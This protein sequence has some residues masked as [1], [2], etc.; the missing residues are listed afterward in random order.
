M[1]LKDQIAAAKSGAAPAAAPAPLA[2]PAPAKKKGGPSF[3]EKLTNNSFADKLGAA[4]DVIAAPVGLAAKALPGGQP[5]SIAEQ[6]RSVQAGFLPGLF[7]IVKDEVGASI[8]HPFSAPKLIYRTAT[9][10]NREGSLAKDFYKTFHEGSPF[11]AGMGDSLARTGLRGWELGNSQAVGQFTP[12]SYKLN[13]FKNDKNLSETQYGQAVKNGTIVPT[14]IEDAGNIAIVAG[15]AA[16]LAG[17][18][19]ARAAS[20]EAALRAAGAS[21]AEIASAAAKAARRAAVADVANTFVD[22]ANWVADAPVRPL[23]VLGKAGREIGSAASPKVSSLLE[24]SE[25]GQRLLTKAAEFKDASAQRK[26]FREKMQNQKVGKAQDAVEP[27]LAAK[28]MKPE[29]VKLAEEQGYKGREAKA[30]A[31]DLESAAILHGSG[32][33]LIPGLLGEAP[34]TLRPGLQQG[35]FGVRNAPS[36]RALSMVGTDLGAKAADL[37]KPAKELLAKDEALRVEGAGMKRGLSEEQLGH[38]PMPSAIERVLSPYEKRAAKL[39]EEAALRSRQAMDAKAKIADAPAPPRPQRTAIL[40]ENIGATKTNRKASLAN[41]RDDVA[42]RENKQI[43]AWE[44]R[45][46]G[47]LSST[48]DRDALAAAKA[49]ELKG[50]ASTRARMAE[51]RANRVAR[52]LRTAEEK[53]ATLKRSLEEGPTSVAPGPYKKVLLKMETLKAGL[54]A[55]GETELAAKVPVT[56]KALQERGIFPE[57]LPGGVEEMAS[58][59]GNAGANPNMQT[60]RAA[61]EK[62]T[63]AGDMPKSVDRMMQ[64]LFEDRATR[65]GNVHLEEM[66]REVVKTPKQLI[67]E[68]IAKIDA[69][70]VITDADQ[71]RRLELEDMQNRGY[72]MYMYAKDKGLASIEGVAPNMIKPDSEFVPKA[73]LRDYREAIKSG[74]WEKSKLG[75]A[76]DTTTRGW[77]HANLALSPNWNVG[78]T[79]SNLGIMPVVRGGMNPLEIPQ[80]VRKV[81]ELRAREV[82]TGQPIFDPRVHSAGGV[83]EAR[84]EFDTAGNPEGKLGKVIDKGYKANESIDNLGKDMYWL[85]LQEKHGFSPAEATKQTLRVMG[86][87]SNLTPLESK[88]KRVMPFYSWQRHAATMGLDLVTKHPWRTAVAAHISQ[89]PRGDPSDPRNQVDPNNPLDTGVRLGKNWMIPIGGMDPFRSTVT[90]PALSP[91]DAVKSVNPIIKAGAYGL[92]DVNLGRLR[93]NTRP[94]GTGPMTASGGRKLGPASL[95]EDLY[96]LSQ[97][98][99]ISR[100]LFAAGSDNVARYDQGS[101]MTS[102]KKVIKQDGPKIQSVLKPFGLPIPTFVDADKQAKNKKAQEEKKRK[103]KKAAQ[104]AKKD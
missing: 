102:K 53:A 21:E 78:N 71:R 28:R 41:F 3:F 83:A 96:F 76:Y 16:K 79:V 46:R 60:R 8:K 91:V 39:R 62:M 68:E 94:A 32:H 52:T 80:F 55:A 25:A 10:N 92:L 57:Y 86:D 104:K 44:T 69:K 11:A 1:A 54:E 18:G 19:A 99:P 13:P 17:A 38:A 84:R 7:N 43:G 90:S 26:V 101:P 85:W 75:R 23:R 74:N 36:E 58:T 65:T 15:G 93:Q 51:V 2:A 72:D 40:A 47:R 34:D 31:A 95:K 30:F 33:G 70:D 56:M 14:L 59:T 27:A 98:S 103:A 64:L 20:T 9:G 22:K 12:L 61:S 45:Q 81:K 4:G 87:F 82:E 6:V 77:K 97:Q 48:M 37:L 50:N 100:A 29:F 73:I 63:K 42:F 66:K 88:V 5:K 24:G 35:M 67:D 49:G 89:I